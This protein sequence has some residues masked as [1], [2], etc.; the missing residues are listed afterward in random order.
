M[1]A[2]SNPLDPAVLAQPFKPGPTGNMPMQYNTIAAGRNAPQGGYSPMNSD[3]SGGNPLAGGPQAGGGYQLSNM[4]G[5]VLGA[6][7]KPTLPYVP[8]PTTG[9]IQNMLGMHQGYAGATLPLLNQ[10]LGEIGNRSAIT[11]QYFDPEMALRQGILEQIASQDNSLLEELLG[12]QRQTKPQQSGSFF[13][14][15]F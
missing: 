11:Q 6:Q 8:P 3:V 5:D 12:L 9:L 7:P 2:G 15:G 1:P 14:K 10:L 13:F 4:W